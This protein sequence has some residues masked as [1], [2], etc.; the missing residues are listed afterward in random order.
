MFLAVSSA[1]LSEAGVTKTR[2]GLNALAAAVLV[3]L[4]EGV[5]ILPIA[6]ILY[7]DGLGISGVLYTPYGLILGEGP[8]APRALRV[9]SVLGADGGSTFGV[10]YGG[11][12][13]SN[14]LIKSDIIVSQPFFNSIGKLVVDIIW[15]VKIG[16]IF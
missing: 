11:K 7:L 14:E 3:L 16:R 13:V 10:L 12:G 15:L 9:D 5:D 6:A 8:R 4:M 1:A 2:E